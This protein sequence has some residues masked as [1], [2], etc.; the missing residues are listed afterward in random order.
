MHRS[1]NKSLPI[2]Y[3]AHGGALYD[4]KNDPRE[5]NNL[6]GAASCRPVLDGMRTALLDWLITADEV[7]QIAPRFSDVCPAP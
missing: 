2:Y 4:L 1:I 3:V 5:V 6:A 7:D